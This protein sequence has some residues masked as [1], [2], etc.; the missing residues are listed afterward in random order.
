MIRVDWK[1]FLPGCRLSCLPDRAKRPYSED[2]TLMGTRLGIFTCIALSVCLLV[3]PR[4][5]P[6]AE[7]EEGIRQIISAESPHIRCYPTPQY[8]LIEKDVK[9]GVGTDF[10]IKYRSKAKKAPPCNYVV[11]S[12]DLEIK[13]EWAEYYAG[14]KGDLLIL[15]S[16]TGPGP[17]GLTIWDLKKRKKVFEGSWSDAIV[18]DDSILYWTET[19]NATHE[20]C[21]GLAEWESQGLGGAIE[22]KVLLRFSDFTITKTKETRCSPRQ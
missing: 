8:F 15:D 20:N 5:L 10:L 9:D 2:K 4:H 13:N 7:K 14:L 3:C 17:S 16:T 21:P 22:T 19:G 1:W 11:E 18:Q 12:G 6:A